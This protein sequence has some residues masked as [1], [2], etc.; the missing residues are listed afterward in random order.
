M[1][2]KPFYVHRYMVPGKLPNRAP[3]AFTAY[4]TPKDDHHVNVQGTF[5]APKDQFCKRLGREFAA[6][7]T[8]ETVRKRDLPRFLAAMSAV[9]EFDDDARQESWFYTLKYIV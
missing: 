3:R 6:R 2:F 9:C 7:A 4:I 1:S 8:S 5:C